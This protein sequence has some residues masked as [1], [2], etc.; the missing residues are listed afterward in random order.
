MTAEVP[1]IHDYEKTWKDGIL[2]PDIT[3]PIYLIDTLDEFQQEFI[4]DGLAGKY[5]E[6]INKLD[7]FHRRS[8]RDDEERYQNYIAYRYQKEKSSPQQC[9]PLS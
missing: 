1:E 3:K 4:L 5:K 9:L 8:R 7:E 2:V 6:R